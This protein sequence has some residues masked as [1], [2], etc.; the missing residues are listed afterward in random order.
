MGYG[1]W[2]RWGRGSCEGYS[3]EFGN[4]YRASVSRDMATMGQSPTWQGSINAKQ[5]KIYPDRASAMKDIEH[6]IE[7][8][9]AIVLDH[10]TIYRAGKLSGS[11][12]RG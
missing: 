4:A 5:K 11:S 2:T 7:A 10:W 8:D 6:E 9:M 12:K 1:R 3:L